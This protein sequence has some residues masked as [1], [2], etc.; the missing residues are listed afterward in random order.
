MSSISDDDVIKILRVL[1]ESKFEE[2]DIEMGD[3]K[4]SVRKNGSAT[5]PSIQGQDFVSTR[6]ETR[7]Q[8]FP[9]PATD[10]KAIRGPALPQKRNNSSPKDYSDQNM[11]EDQGLIP[12]KSPLMGMFYPRSK[13]E[14]PPFVKVGSHVSKDDTVCLIEVMKTFTSVTAGVEGAVAKICAESS[15]LVEY[16]QIL[17]LIKPENGKDTGTGQ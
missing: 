15:H 5:T 13:P 8:N 3:F 17:F 11:S 6:P 4:L 1:D 14:A 10:E 9:D 12:I 16:G 7:P 2:L